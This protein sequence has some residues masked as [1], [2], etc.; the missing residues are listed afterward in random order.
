MDYYPKS[1]QRLIEALTH[2]PTIGR[3]SAQRLAMNIVEKPP[4]EVDVLIQALI[5]VKEKVTH[6]S[7]CNNLTDREICSVCEDQTRDTSVVC[8]VEDVQALIAIE[9]TRGFHGLYHV[10]GGL[11]NPL[12][13]VTPEKLHLES[14]VQRIAH[15]DIKELVL[16]ISPTVEGDVTAHF[17]RDVLKDTDVKLTRI[18]SGIPIGAS[19]EYFDDMTLINALADRRKME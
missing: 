4:E 2:L 16:A 9:K 14:L 5:D 7:I 17:I 19:L 13:G 1:V 15:D 18:A 12:H 10:L 11:L 6:C 8:V 3:K